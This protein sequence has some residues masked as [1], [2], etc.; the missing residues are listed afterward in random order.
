MGVRAGTV[1]IVQVSDTHVSRKRAYFVDNWDV[2]VGEMRRAPPQLIVH[3]GDV[4]FD[5]SGD[6]DDIAFARQQKDRLG[7]PW[8][9]IPGNHDTGESPL[10]VRLNQPVDSER[11]AR[12]RRHYGEGRWC[13]DI[14]E[15]RLV[16]ID[17]ALL[18]SDLAEER[19]Q[20]AF[21]ERALKERC[22]R[23]VM[24]FQHLPPFEE[25]PD[26]TAFTAM[27]VPAAPR[28]RLL[29]TCLQGGVAVIAC[30]HLHVYR[31]MHYAGIDIVWAPATS[32][33]NIVDKQRRGLGVPRAG[34][35]EWTLE[36]TAAT[37][38]LIEPPLMIT[39]DIGAW[40]AAHG[41][42]TNMP[43]RPLAPA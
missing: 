16:G 30:G 1:R 11:L 27:A 37:H 7:I 28:K 36:G 3:S 13:R 19:E 39:H 6:E 42:T 5:G 10:A 15:W 33:F 32:F 38:R 12:W 26:D 8:L 20:W 43:P 34:Y 24:L 21:L 18:G 35:V 22:G 41:S 17:T 9:A 31:Q 4:S 40:N 25:A 14:G 29:D 2:F 23:P